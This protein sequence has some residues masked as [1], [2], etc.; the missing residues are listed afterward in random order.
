LLLHGLLQDAALAQMR[1]RFDVARWQPS[2]LAGKSF[3]DA[4]GANHR[5]APVLLRNTYA[6][7]LP[8]SVRFLFIPNYQHGMGTIDHLAAVR[9]MVDHDLNGTAWPR[10]DAGWD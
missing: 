7:G 1:E 5:H 2:V 3:R 10:V 8:A 6:E 9:A 4:V